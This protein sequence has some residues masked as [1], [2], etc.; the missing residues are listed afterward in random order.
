MLLRLPGRGLRRLLTLLALCGTGQGIA[1]TQSTKPEGVTTA[2]G[3]AVFGKLKYGPDFKQFDYVNPDAPKGGSFTYGQPGSF[4]S[5]NQ[6][7]LLGTFP[8]ILMFLADSLM[9]QSR[10][11]AAS[12][13]CLVCKS[14]RWPRDLAWV[15]FQINHD[16]RFNDGQPVT[17]EDV[18]FSANLGKG[19]TLA[20]FS[21]VAQIVE[22]VEK[23]GP[24][25][26]RFHFTMKNNPTLATVVGLM[27]IM[28][29]HYW[30]NRDPFRPSLDFPVGLGPYKL[31]KVEPGRSITFHR[32]RNYW[33]ANHPINRGRHN[34]DVLRNSYYRDATP[35]TEAF[36]VGLSD[37]RL[38]TSAADLRQEA[39]LPA[40]RKGDIRSVR[41]P[42]ENGAIYNTV[43]I[44]ARRPFLSD[45]RALMLT[46]L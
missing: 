25:R 40:R 9:K 3:Y 36:R 21:R 44:N 29:R 27:P 46:V 2:H 4:D 5:V 34:F 33:A 17:V 45:R 22:R 8:P 43:N 6:I 41:L 19:L 37:L 16:A 26:V 42:Y 28:P 10:D 30:Q 32:D 35:L 1:A 15:E 24:D 18:I 7:A 12:Y 14:V 23:T 13:Y 20:A 11:E 38:D 39:T 31:M